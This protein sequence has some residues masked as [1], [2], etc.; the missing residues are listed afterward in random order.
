M[1]RVLAKGGRPSSGPCVGGHS[2]WI[3]LAVFVALACSCLKANEPEQN[4]FVT[5]SLKFDST[6]RLEEALAGEP[7]SPSRARSGDSRLIQASVASYSRSR[8]TPKITNRAVKTSPQSGG[9]ISSSPGWQEIPNSTLRSVCPT[10]TPAEAVVGCPAVIEAWNS[11]VAD[12]KR[13]R[14]IIWG[15]GHNDYW[16]NELYSFDMNLLKMQR[17][18][19]PSPISNVQSCPEAYVD[20]KPSSRHTYGA[21]SYIAHADRMFVFGGGKSSCGNFSSGTWTLDLATLQW[22]QMNPSG[23]HPP[24]GAGQVSD[25]DSDSKLV[26][27]HDYVN[28][29]YAYNFDKNSWTLV[30]ADPYGIDYHMN[31]VIDPKR[32]LFIVIGAA[33]SHNGGIQVFNIGSKG[34]HARQS[35]SVSGCADLLSS[36]SPGLAYDPVQDRVVGW[37]NFGNT[38]YIFNPDTRTCAAQTLPGGPTDSHHTGA[39]STTTGTFGRLRY[40]PDKGVFALVNEADS[41]AYILRLTPSVQK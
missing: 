5:D 36:A 33:A 38:V 22:Q 25:Y 21:L 23:T 3:L 14:L 4:R 15:G 40:F 29:L 1:P 2:S 31:A 7:Q 30:T 17:L 39:A 35:W 19:D 12:T 32:K 9:G 11:A 24:G 41:D 8:T 34:S 6:P 13:N 27:L 20:G 26:Y 28:G 16:G 10:P 37:P 18:N